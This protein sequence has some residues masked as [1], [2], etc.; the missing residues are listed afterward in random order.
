MKL[1]KTIVAGLLVLGMGSAFAA[2][3]VALT[4]TQLDNVSAGGAA[5]SAAAVSLAIGLIGAATQDITL[6]TV[7]QTNLGTAINP[8]FQFTSASSSLSVGTAF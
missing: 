8:A 7:T 6:T 2:E 1:S 5:A 4:E 3:P